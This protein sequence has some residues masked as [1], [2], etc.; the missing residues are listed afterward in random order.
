MFDGLVDAATLRAHL[1]D[2]DWIII[3]CRHSLSDFGAGRRDYESD[4]I[5]GARFAD[6]E[7]DLSGP[8]TGKNGRHP[9]PNPQKFL[10][11]LNATGA[12]E[13]SQIVAYDAGADMFAARLWHLARWIGHEFVAVL[14]GGYS[15]WRA[16][17]YPTT[18]S[19]P[20]REP[21]TLRMR[22]A[23]DRAFDAFTLRSL[24]GHR[25]HI[26]LDARAHER[27]AGQVEPIDP[28]AG[29]IPGAHN[30]HY[31]NNFDPNGHWKSAPQ[32]R[33][34]FTEF[35]DPAAIINYCGS[36]ISA[37]ANLFSMHVAGLRGAGIYPGSWSEWC[38]DPEN[39][40]ERG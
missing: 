9:L 40:V 11:F 35:G 3:D 34:E 6:V 22:P 10:A 39:P 4:H 14:D 20:A 13:S 17:G 23:H 38:S 27:Y 16:A 31:K 30:R 2:L 25:R 29:H 15:A 18:S 12:N 37:A 28:V 5:P 19:V 7:T 32:L 24:I 8:K 33:A 36:G 26:L 21:G 1:D